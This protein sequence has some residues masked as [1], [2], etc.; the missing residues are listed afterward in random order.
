MH[1][2]FGINDPAA[3]GQTNTLM[4]QADTGRVLQRRTAAEA[5][6]HGSAVLFN[7]GAVLYSKLR[8]YLNKVV[9]SDFRGI[10]TTELVVLELEPE[11]LDRKFFAWFLRSPQTVKAL[12]K[13]SSGTKMPRANMKLFRTLPV[14]L[15]PLSEQRRI[16]EYLDGLAGQV[17]ALARLQSE[18]AAELDAL[19]PSILDRAFKGELC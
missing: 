3:K 2:A 13:D 19:L 15:P 4:P 1:Q 11:K 9:V 18:T 8:P 6:I 16:V 17:A 5:G 12:V 7:E 10:A 14:P